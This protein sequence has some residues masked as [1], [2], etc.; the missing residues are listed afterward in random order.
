MTRP[1]SPLQNMLRG[2][3]ISFHCGV[4]VF[5]MVCEP[6]EVKAKV[7]RKN[8]NKIIITI[9]STT[10]TTTEPRFHRGNRQ[11]NCVPVFVCLFDSFFLFLRT[12][13]QP[14]SPFP[15]FFFT[16]YLHTFTHLSAMHDR[17]CSVRI[18]PREV[19]KGVRFSWDRGDEK[20]NTS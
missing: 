9:I 5:M 16:H 14:A 4:S 20:K 10:T 11:L 7:T 3:T 19:D 12:F 15:L 6:R 2:M 8:K 1:R 17:C 18:Q 13:V